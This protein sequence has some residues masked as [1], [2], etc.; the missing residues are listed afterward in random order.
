MKAFHELQSKETINNIM[1]DI[2]KLLTQILI[3]HILVS[4]IDGDEEFLSESIMKKLL[5]T[6]I[7]VLVYHIILKKYF[8]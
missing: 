7:A 5:Y 8:Y 2:C 6:I 1:D 3:V 4:C